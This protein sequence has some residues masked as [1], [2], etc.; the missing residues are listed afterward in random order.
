MISVDVPLTEVDVEFFVGLY[1]NGKT[2]S[3]PETA[4][5][6]VFG[7]AVQDAVTGAENALAP[8]NPETF[9]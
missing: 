6:I 1:R 8:R 9:E 7:L 3:D 4:A 2:D 5:D